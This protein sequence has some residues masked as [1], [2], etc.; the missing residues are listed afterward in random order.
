M[1]VVPRLLRR[2]LDALGKIVKDR[3]GARL[4][5]IAGF[6][7]LFG[8]V[9]TGEYLAFRQGLAEVLDLGPPS[10][11]LTLYI[12]EAFLALVLVISVLSFVATGLWTFYRASDTAFLLST[13]VPLADLFWLR[14]VETFL[15]TSWAFVLLGV[16][17]FL[18][19]G[20]SHDGGLP[21][22]LRAFILLI[23]MMVLAGALGTLLTAL[24]GAAFR[25]YR[26]RTVTVLATVI[27]AGAFALLVG[28]HVVPS[29]ADFYLIF[30]P[31]I[32][33][34]K[35]A[36]LLF[37]E[38]RFWFWPSHP[39]AVSLFASVRV[40]TAG[41]DALA[42]A[43]WVLPAL[44]LV[45]AGVIGRRLFAATLPVVAE[46][47]GLA[48]RP[49]GRRGAALAEFPR[50][51]RGPVGAV[52]ERD[53]V[54]LGR[55]PQEL[56]RAGF[57]VFLLALYTAILL[58]APLAEA[59]EEPE[60]VAR[61][62]FL[63]LMA[64]GYFVTAFGIRFVFPSLSLEGRGAWILFAGPL[65]IERLFLGKLLAY[66]TILGLAVGPIAL[67]GA[68]R[69][70]TDPALLGAFA[71]LLAL[72]IGTTVTVSLAFGVLWPNFREANAERLA[73]NGGGLATIVLCL[74][75]VAAVGW[76]GGQC[77]RSFLAG[78]SILAYLAAAVALSGAIVG[79]ATAAA[80]RRLGT[81]EI[82]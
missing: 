31:G 13:P 2:R 33:N 82:L 38:H 73:T 47:P 42:A 75:Y 62:F 49:G 50:L 37:I 9:M 17:A 41:S 57:I 29:P 40:T 5:V 23:L 4:A 36:S 14:A 53:L 26:A 65:A 35:P 12:L 52:I 71:L 56:A 32:P 81:L 66:S 22:Y 70:V 39:L 80:R 74:G 44:A 77:V 1:S 3:E 72:L 67:G 64:V 10:A 8:L 34:G 68:L 55:S 27:L 46:G 48:G 18:A 19:L 54:I 59:L 15:L 43:A 11:A 6:V 58:V 78:E 20:V 60:A 63:D 76:V 16:P 24:A 69:L 21:F 25:R 28:R 45:A 7:I 30:E 51:L 79:G 61:L